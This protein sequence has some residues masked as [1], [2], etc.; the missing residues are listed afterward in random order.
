MAAP[1]APSSKAMRKVL[2]AG[3]SDERTIVSKAPI[4][5]GISRNGIISAAVAA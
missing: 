5:A 1:S 4:E 2:R 3:N